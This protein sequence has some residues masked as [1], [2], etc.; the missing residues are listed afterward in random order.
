MK[1]ITYIFTIMTMLLCVMVCNPVQ[2]QTRKEKKAAQK[3]QWEFEQKKLEMQRQRTLDSLANL[4]T[5]PQETFVEIPCYEASRSDAEYF[6]ELGT[7]KDTE[8]EIARASA[9]QNAQSIM[10]DRLGH[11]VKGLATDYSKTVAVSGKK[12]DME[13]ILEREFTSVVD[14]VLNDADNPCEKWSQDRSG[15]W[16]VYYT[17]E[18]RKTV[19]VDELSNAVSNNEKLKAEFDRDQ[20]RKY[21]E[22]YMKKQ[23]EFQQGNN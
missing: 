5:Q 6:R 16:N 17:I 14:K 18:I 9:V 10:K 23:Q 20:F 4:P 21:A 22:E 13:R 12:A 8:K 2:A 11:A 1:K 15:N 7:G 3:S 19:L